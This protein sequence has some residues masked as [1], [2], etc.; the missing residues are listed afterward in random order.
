MAMSSGFIGWSP[1]LVGRALTLGAPRAMTAANWAPP[2]FATDRTEVRDRLAIPSDAIVFGLVGSLSWNPKVSYAYG[3]ELV[4]AIRRVDRP[5]IRVLIVGDGEGLRRLRE[6]AHGDQRVI[7]PGRVPRDELGGYLA[8]MD[9][10]SLPQSVDRVGS[11]RYTTKLSEYLTAGLPVMTGRLPLA[12]DLD[13]GWLW[14]LAGRAPWDA[15]YVRG[16]AALM[17]EIRIDEVV[18]RREQVPAKLMLFDRA[19]QQ[20]L[21]ASFLAEIIDDS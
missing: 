13:D 10:A 7:L 1:Y 20:R 9:V 2:V 15:A 11:F 18:A 5:D 3:V 16:V 4:R 8:A 19:R 21:V 17:G 6:L 12:Y 14:R